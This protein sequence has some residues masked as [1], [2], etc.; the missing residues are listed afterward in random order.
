MILHF[1]IKMVVFISDTQT[2]TE[3]HL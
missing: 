2:F 1:L 3:R